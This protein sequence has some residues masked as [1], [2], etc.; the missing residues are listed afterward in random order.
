M[1]D[2]MEK[3]NACRSMDRKH[4]GKRPL[5]RSSK[6]CEYIIMM[7]LKEDEWDVDGSGTG[8]YQW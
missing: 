2:V 4:F 8:S 5:G 1:A 7:N 3:R 6:R